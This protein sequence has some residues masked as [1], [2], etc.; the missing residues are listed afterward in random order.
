M[1]EYDDIIYEYYIP[2]LYF[3]TFLS[4]NY[5]QYFIN[6]CRY[7]DLTVT[8]N[9]THQSGLILSAGIYGDKAIVML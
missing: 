6:F 5:F 7:T 3:S 8:L 1:Y 9:N 2:V 4:K